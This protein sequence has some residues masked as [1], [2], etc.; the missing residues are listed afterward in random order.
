MLVCQSASDGHILFSKYLHHHEIIG[1]IL[2]D[3]ILLFLS[4]ILVINRHIL[5]TEIMLGYSYGPYMAKSMP[6]N[7]KILETM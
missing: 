6:Q 1:M 4:W 7:Y 3:R 5:F 2:F